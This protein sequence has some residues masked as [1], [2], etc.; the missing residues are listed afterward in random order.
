[1][2]TANQAAAVA[3]AGPWQLS[4]ACRGMETAAFFPP[5]EDQRARRRDVN[6]AKA[7]CRGC[8]VIDQCLGHALRTREPYGV[9]GGRSEGERAKMLGVETLRYPAPRRK[10]NRSAGG[11][12][13]TA[14]SDD[15][16]R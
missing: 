5:V 1:M 13:G 12:K 2:I 14:T 8:P 7:V 9:W 15:S 6:G 10:R 3:G 4:A 16:I 11:T